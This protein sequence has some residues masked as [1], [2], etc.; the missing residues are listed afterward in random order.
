MLADA[1]V[2]LGRTDSTLVPVQGYSHLRE[3]QI[4]GECIVEAAAGP[5]PLTFL[6]RLLTLKVNGNSM[7]HL[8]AGSIEVGAQVEVL[9]KGCRG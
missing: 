6:T 9:P 3:V 7:F 4:D 2:A 1:T 8:V 5:V